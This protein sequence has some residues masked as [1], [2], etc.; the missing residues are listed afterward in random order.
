MYPPGDPRAV[1]AD[2]PGLARQETAPR[3]AEVFEL[4]PEDPDRVLP[5]GS[6]CW[7]VRA[8]NFCIEITQF[9]AGDELAEPSLPDE[10]LVLVKSGAISASH[11]DADP[12]EVSDPSVVVVPS[13]P[14]RLQAITDA[15]VVRVFP[16]HVEQVIARARNAD[17]YRSA[18]PNVRQLPAP[19]TGI[20]SGIRVHRLADVPPSPGRL[21]RIFRSST[22]M[23]NWF[24][25]EYQPRD[26]D[27]LS[28]HSHDD[29]EQGSIT[30]AG[31]FVH[32]LR[33]PWTQRL[34]YW[35]AD[36]H[37]LVASPSVTII[38]PPLIHTTQGVGEGL[39]QLVDV[40]APP[41]EDF[42]AQGWVLNAGD[43]P[44]P[45]EPR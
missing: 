30:L 37:H 4:S 21:G 12:V 24:P 2:Q 36:E 5:N 44:E 29:F 41:R 43:Y 32:H 25:D 39:H 13:G 9:V 10:H 38:P 27:R 40:F 19:G 35:R 28:P 23:V 1:L 42:L 16:A 8:Q 7:L 34:A 22:L 14:S 45:G 31:D 3:P 6:R 33:A 18:D 20:G 15:W 26:P 17:S 11:G